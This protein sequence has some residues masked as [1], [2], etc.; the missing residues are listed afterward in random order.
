M[1]RV[2]L[3][4]LTILI[5]AMLATLGSTPLF[6][7][8]PPPF[9]VEIADIDKGAELARS[10]QAKGI[11]AVIH[12]KNMYVENAQTNRAIWLG[13]KVPL[14]VVRVTIREA[15]A[16]NPYIC[17]V[18]VVG[19]RGE[20]PPEKVNNT[21]HVGGSDEAALAMKLAVI[22]AEELLQALDRAKSI[23]DLHKFLHDRNAAGP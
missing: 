12:P 19:D 18:H 21:I 13:R 20:L 16:F 17:F 23:E 2:D 10:L 22:P 6:A 9:T 11:P 1:R 15:L 5:T 3:I 7:A 14:E 4:R 8:S